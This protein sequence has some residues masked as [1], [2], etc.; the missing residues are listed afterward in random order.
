M[1]KREQR[2]KVNLDGRN[3]GTLRVTGVRMDREQW[4]D[5]YEDNVD[6]A[7]ADARSGRFRKLAGELRLCGDPHIDDKP[8]RVHPKI[9]AWVKE[10]CPVRRRRGNPG[11]DRE[12]EDLVCFYYD[13][14]RSE[15]DTNDVPEKELLLWI[16][17]RFS[18][19]N[20]S[21]RLGFDRVRNIVRKKLQEAAVEQFPNA[22]S[23]K[24]P[25]TLLKNHLEQ[26]RL[27]QRMHRQRFEA[28]IEKQR[29]KQRKAGN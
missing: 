8:R 16:A 11:R 7:V 1:R 26:F 29:E 2:R 4:L 24:E 6:A 9:I 5:I 12:L 28:I 23:K 15:Y 18:T 27:D 17:E 14:A 3:L 10:G 13:R 21:Y 25:L 20:P 22:A 19:V